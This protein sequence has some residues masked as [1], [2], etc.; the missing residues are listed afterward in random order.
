MLLVIVISIVKFESQ[1]HSNVNV[2]PPSVTTRSGL[3]SE[4]AAGKDLQRRAIQ[5]IASKCCLSLRMNHIST[6]PS[7]K[8]QQILPMTSHRVP[9]LYAI[10]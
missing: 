8:V 7:F 2:L 6:E 9:W 5:S 3:R 4:A 10:T 1:I